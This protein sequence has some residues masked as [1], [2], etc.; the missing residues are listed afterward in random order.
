MSSP[1]WPS[2]RNK[3]ALLSSG[4]S[5]RKGLGIPG[6]KFEKVT[7][8]LVVLCWKEPRRIGAWRLAGD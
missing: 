1:S 6:Y 3:T 7:V 4:I 8:G 2:T 5:Q